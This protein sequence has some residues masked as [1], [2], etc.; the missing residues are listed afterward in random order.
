MLSVELEDFDGSIKYAEYT[1][2]KIADEVDKYRL[3]IEGYKGT[4]G[5]SMKSHK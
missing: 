4:A 5:D 2:F 3:L 1:T